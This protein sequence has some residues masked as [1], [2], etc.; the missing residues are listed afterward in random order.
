[1][2]IYRITSINRPL[3]PNY[4]TNR[5]ILLTGLIVIIVTS[6]FHFS[7]NGPSI[8]SIIYGTKAGITVFLVWAISREVD[9]DHETAAFVPVIL[10]LVPVIFFGM[11]PLLA[12]YWLLLISRIVNRSTGSK[13]GILDSLTSLLLGMYLSFEITWFFGIITSASLFIDSRISATDRISL[14][15][16]A[17]AI[18]G[19]LYI[20]VRGTGIPITDISLVKAVALLSMLLLF[21]PTLLGSKRPQSKGDRTG[22]PLEAI[23]VKACMAIF[24]A[25][26]I[27]FILADTDYTRSWPVLWCIAAGIGLYRSLVGYR[28]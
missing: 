4:P 23:R 15:L 24:L 7:L 1:M 28:S 22:E 11:N 20:I 17:L 25:T 8:T 5:L 14:I 6:L 16:S 18:S 9:P 2:D 27:G 10:S 26:A 21:L 3:D 19:T 13:A 12:M